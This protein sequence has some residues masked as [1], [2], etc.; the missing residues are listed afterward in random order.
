MVSID[1]IGEWP[2]G[3]I[4][5]FQTSGLTEEKVL[6]LPGIYKTL[7]LAGYLIFAFVLKGDSLS[8]WRTVLY[9]PCLESFQI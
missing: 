2:N 1:Q 7:Q 9:F 6:D 3:A 8:L 4:A 5:G